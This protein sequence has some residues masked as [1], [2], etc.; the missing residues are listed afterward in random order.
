MTDI[1]AANPN[2][3]K[4]YQSLEWSEEQ[5]KEYIKYFDSSLELEALT[6][7]PD[8]ETGLLNKKIIN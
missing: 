6:Q 5:L 1:Y 3:K 2:L 4:A 7:E 8:F